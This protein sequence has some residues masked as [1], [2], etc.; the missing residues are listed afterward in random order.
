MADDGEQHRRPV[1]NGQRQGRN[2]LTETNALHNRHRWDF[3]LG[4]SRY[5]LLDLRASAQLEYQLENPPN[6]DHLWASLPCASGS[7]LQHMAIHKGGAAQARLAL[8][9][10]ESSRMFLRNCRK[11]SVCFNAGRMEMEH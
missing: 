10:R 3:Y 5:N 7:P 4:L 9:I 6:A 11:A 8:E 1:Q 2:A